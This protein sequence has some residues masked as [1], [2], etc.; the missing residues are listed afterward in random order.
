M[1]QLSKLPRWLRFLLVGVTGFM[2]DG[3]LLVFLVHKLGFNPIFSRFVS[4]S[5][6]VLITW[7]MNRWITF[8]SSAQHNPI[9]NLQRYFVVSVLGFGLNFVVYIWLLATFAIVERYPILGVVPSAAMSAIFTYWSNV[10]FAF[11]I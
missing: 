6:A 5:V 7:W 3:G 8:Q 2:I 10:R 11:R 4:F 9:K 1:I